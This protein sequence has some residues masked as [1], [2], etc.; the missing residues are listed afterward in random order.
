MSVIELFPGLW[1]D[2]RNVKIARLMD[3]QEQADRAGKIYRL[4]N[5]GVSL[6]ELGRLYEIS[7]AH[8]SNIY[9]AE[10]R[11]IEGEINER[12]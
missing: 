9:R 3:K 8:A 2:A 5:R 6:A 11:K 12:K 7:K 10:R 4:R 1:G